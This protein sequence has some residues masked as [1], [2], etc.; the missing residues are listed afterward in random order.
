MLPLIG[1]FCYSGLRISLHFSCDGNGKSND[2]KG[3]RPLD[4]TSPSS[5]GFIR[6]YVSVVVSY[7]LVLLELLVVPSE[8]RKIN[9]REV[10]F[11]TGNCDSGRAASNSRQVGLFADK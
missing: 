10:G 4:S 1:I 2:Y 11:C 9:L 5:H 6:R 3:R 7:V 8:K